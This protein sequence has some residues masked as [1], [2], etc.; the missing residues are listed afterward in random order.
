MEHTPMNGTID[1][2]EL[3]IGGWIG[4]PMSCMSGYLFLWDQCLP[5]QPRQKAPDKKP[6]ALIKDELRKQKS[7]QL[8]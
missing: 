1:F 4:F 6:E 7:K 5:E 8:Q 2:S 3:A